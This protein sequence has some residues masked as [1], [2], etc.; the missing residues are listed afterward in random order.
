MRSACSFS[1]LVTG[2]AIMVDAD[3]SWLSQAKLPIWEV[4]LNTLGN[5]F[6]D[7]L[8]AS[9]CFWELC[10]EKYWYWMD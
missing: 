10:D 5:S 7:S 1:I 8:G 3:K 4:M 2:H 9:L 6:F